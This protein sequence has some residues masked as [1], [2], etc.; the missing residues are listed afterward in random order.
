MQWESSNWSLKSGR[1]EQMQAFLAGREQRWQIGL[2]WGWS[3]FDGWWGS[4]DPS[5]LLLILFVMCVWRLMG[6]A[7]DI[8]GFKN[9]IRP[10]EHA[11]SF[12]ISLA[13]ISCVT[14]KIRLI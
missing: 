4:D 8:L 7:Y 1:A 11:S 13:H 6:G 10:H 9:S 12:A 3:V 14:R 5:C 2:R